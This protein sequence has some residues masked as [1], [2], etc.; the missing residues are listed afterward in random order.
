[1]NNSSSEYNY[2]VITFKHVRTVQAYQQIENEESYNLL[3]L[4]LLLF[5]SI[6]NI[7]SHLFILCFQKEGSNESD[8]WK[9]DIN[10]LKAAFNEKTKAIVVNNPM[11]PLGKVCIYNSYFEIMLNKENVK[12]FLT[13]NMKVRSNIVSRLSRESFTHMKRFPRETRMT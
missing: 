9:F 7:F 5:I 13:L 2:F 4:Y 3:Y 1:M 6:F 8:D 10:N 12:S 11:N